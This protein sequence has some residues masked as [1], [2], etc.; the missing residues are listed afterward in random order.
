MSFAGELKKSMERENI[1]AA[2]LAEKTGICK[3][4]IS[5]YL[6]G[7][8]EPKGV[9]IKKIAEVMEVNYDFKNVPVFIAAEMLGKS[10]QF[11]RIGLQQGILP[12]GKAVQLSSKYSYH[13]SQKL[14][15]EYM[16]S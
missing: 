4:S 13:I 3:S 14:L 6:S 16:G 9:A 8:S 15:E 5:Q 12:F 10:E 11:I 1:S 2:E 7:K